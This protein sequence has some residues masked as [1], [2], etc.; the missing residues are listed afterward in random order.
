MSPSRGQ[1]AGG[2]LGSVLA[3]CALAAPMI[4]KWE[5]WAP[6]AY[7]D[8]VAIPT[9]CAGVTEGV[10]PN[11]T[12]TDAECQ[13]KTA[14][15]EV[16]IGLAIA[17]CL[18]ANLPTATRAAFTSIAYNLGPTKFCASSM[19]RHAVAGDLRAACASI[20]LYTKAAGRE[21]PGLVS[22]RAEERALCLRGFQP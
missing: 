13:Q 10:I 6:V 8:P 3:A 18:P 17:Q 20:S 14:E 21:L 19:A 5:G 15:A 2:V 1:V 11:R 16:R 22:R 4:V 9:V 7:K 12:Y